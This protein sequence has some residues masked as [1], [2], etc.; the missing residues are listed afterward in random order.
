MFW[1]QS[2]GISIGLGALW[3][4][5]TLYNPEWGGIARENKFVIEMYSR[6]LHKSVRKHE[7]AREVAKELYA[8]DIQQKAEIYDQLLQIKEEG[9]SGNGLNVDEVDLLAA[10][11]SSGF[12]AM[13]DSWFARWF[14]GKKELP[15]VSKEIDEM[16]YEQRKAL[17]QET[18]GN[19]I[20]VN[21]N[22]WPLKGLQRHTPQWFKVDQEKLVKDSDTAKLVHAL[23]TDDQR[24][25]TFLQETPRPQVKE[26]RILR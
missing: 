12:R 26:R 6:G 2:L 8:K 16:P 24:Q 7:K 4:A 21:W 3:A 17:E 1:Y 9:K 5:A 18:L 19:I 23:S 25:P 11:T 20:A 14:L 15:K 10:G 13:E 22:R